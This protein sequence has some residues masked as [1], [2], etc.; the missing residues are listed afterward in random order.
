MARKDKSLQLRVIDDSNLEP[1]SALRLD[2]YETEQQER[3]FSPAVRL[4]NY[5]T[6]QRRAKELKDTEEIERLD[7]AD[8][9]KIELR[10]HQPGIDV[11]IEA[12]SVMLDVLEK[13]WGDSFIRRQAIPW[14]WFALIGSVIAW[15]VLWSLA[16]VDKAEIEA[17]RIRTETATAIM[18]EAREEREAVELIDRINSSVREFI[19]A[20]TVE[21]LIQLVR[22]PGRVAPLMGHYYADK[23]VN[24][25]RFKSI[26]ILEPA[27]LGNRGN[28]WMASV[29]LDN[30]KV[31]S[32][33]LEIGESGEPRVDW[34][35]FVCYQPMP[36]D[37]YARQRPS[38]VSLDFRVYLEKDNF[39][40][41]EFAND[42]HWVCFRLTAM[43]GQESVFGYAEADSDVA[44]ALLRQLERNDTDR[45][46][47]L[48][49]LVI[50]EGL[51]S[52]NGVV[53]EKLLCPRWLYLVPP[54]SGS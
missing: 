18:E 6:E 11:L 28:F 53:I 32:L 17:I 34:E 24:Q 33:V 21:H 10:T 20:T 27:T 29:A 31:Q 44:R 7:S 42:E 45:V 19:G 26:R 23:P 13:D 40:N 14:G 8:G 35:T 5:E 41:Y 9:D 37:D 51:Q 49:R 52:R 2:N 43:E 16:R 22:Q 38:G 50:P 15:A 54:D 30:G 36:W 25:G 39:H 1:S 47:V 12:E 48:L 4:D 3:E 46:S